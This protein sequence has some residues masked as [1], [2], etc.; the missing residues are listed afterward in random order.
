[1]TNRFFCRIFGMFAKIL[2]HLY[3]LAIQELILIMI[4]STYN[5]LM[6]IILIR[7]FQLFKVEGIY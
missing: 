5:Y 2:Y 6:F 3:L 1:M 4:V 7:R